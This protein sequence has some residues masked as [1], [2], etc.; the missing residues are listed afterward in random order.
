MD[1][2]STGHTTRGSD[3]HSLRH[4]DAC[5]HIVTALGRRRARQPMRAAVR[6][7]PTTT[8]L[9]GWEARL[10]F[11]ADQ[12]G[13]GSVVGLDDPPGGVD[14]LTEIVQ[15]RTD[16]AVISS[17]PGAIMQTYDTFASAIPT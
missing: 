6:P 3:A 13:V 14:R 2:L 15:A 5:A 11:E 8:P 7:L 10:V 1:A 4:M 16:A 9:Q 12:V 17:S